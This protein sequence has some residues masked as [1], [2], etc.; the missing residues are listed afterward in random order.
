M[1]NRKIVKKLRS[2]LLQQAHVCVCV[3]CVV[4]GFDKKFVGQENEIPQR[5]SIGGFL[6]TTRIIG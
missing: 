6:S 3:C 4:F 2:F 1:Q 5:G